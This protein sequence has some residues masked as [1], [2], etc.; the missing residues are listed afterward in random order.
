MKHPVNAPVATRVSSTACL[1]LSTTCIVVVLL[2]VGFFAPTGLAI[3]VYGGYYGEWIAG[4]QEDPMDGWT[5]AVSIL[6]V[7][8]LVPMPFPHDGTTMSLNWECVNDI[9]SIGLHKAPRIGRLM[10]WPPPVSWYAERSRKERYLPPDLLQE[11]LHHL[12]RRKRIRV[13]W[14]SNPPTEIT[15]VLLDSSRT[16]FLFYDRFNRSEGKAALRTFLDDLSTHS[17]LLVEI[18]WANPEYSDS[19]FRVPLDGAAEAISDITRRCLNQENE[20]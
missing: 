19:H 14:D 18:R 9:A 13:R 16:F 20:R 8:P 11:E 3:Q 5:H 17:A 15:G 7:R 6:G 2:T 4:S 10:E 12:T 1:V